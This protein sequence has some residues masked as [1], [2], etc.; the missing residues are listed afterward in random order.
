MIPA[1][2]RIYAFGGTQHGPAGDPPGRGIAD[3][4]TNPADYRPFLRA[5]LDA[6]D[7]WVVHDKAP[8]ASVYPR[9]DP[10]LEFRL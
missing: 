7:E 5:L 2:V 8:P 3:N 10:A 4:L 1:D 6:L 9:L